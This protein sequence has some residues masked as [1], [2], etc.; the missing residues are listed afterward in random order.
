MGCFDEKTGCTFGKNRSDSFHKGVPCGVEV[1]GGIEDDEPKRP[2]DCFF[3]AASF[4]SFLA[5]RQ[6]SGSKTRGVPERKIL[7]IKLLEST[8]SPAPAPIC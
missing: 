3:I 7:G 1:S 2:A 4:F 8:V 6:I 5:V